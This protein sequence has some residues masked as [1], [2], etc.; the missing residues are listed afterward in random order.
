VYAPGPIVSPEHAA[1]LLMGFGVGFIVGLTGMGG[2]TLMTPFLIIVLR[3]RP[4]FAIG[5]DLVYA[6]LTKIAGATIHWKQGMVDLRIVR[7]LAFGSLPAGIAGSLAVYAMGRLSPAADRYLRDAVGLTL[8]AVTAA[9]ALGGRWRR[10]KPAQWRS[11][12][13][14]D[15]ATAAS[16]ALI[17]AVVGFTSIG[18]GTLVLPF[19]IWAYDVPAARLVGTDI[20][21]AAILLAVTG[22][23]FT[24]FGTVQWSVLPWLLAGSLP[25]VALGSRLA[26]RLPE[27]AL[28]AILMAVLLLSAWKLLK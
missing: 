26:P 10:R 6:A 7:T 16:G 14:R 28:R 21:H 12:R 4:S 23:F 22:A 8:V 18:S 2:A 15:L 13:R 17:G 25:A 9:L 1:L 20:F 5:T 24:G 19:L 27:K 3:V 11:E